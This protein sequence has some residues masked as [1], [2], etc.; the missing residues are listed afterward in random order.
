MKPEKSGVSECWRVRVNQAAYENMRCPLKLTEL[1]AHSSTQ[2]QPVKQEMVMMRVAYITQQSKNI[3]C[4]I[5]DLTT[6]S[7]ADNIAPNVMH[8]SKGH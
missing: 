7:V 1:Q 5:S 4:K 2:L 8:K 6:G 3:I